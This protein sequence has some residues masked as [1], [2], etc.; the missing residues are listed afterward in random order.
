MSEDLASTRTLSEWLELFEFWE[1]EA[2][3]VPSRRWPLATVLAER[4]AVRVRAELLSRYGALPM[5]DL[6]LR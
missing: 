4:Y 1:A 5:T 2:A 3:K 6:A